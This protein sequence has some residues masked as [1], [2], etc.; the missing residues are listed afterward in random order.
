MFTNERGLQISTP[1]TAPLVPFCLAGWE[2]SS[3]SQVRNLCLGGWS[4]TLLFSTQL[5]VSS[6]ETYFIEVSGTDLLSG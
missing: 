4:T 6:N 5:P 3:K 2:W 1:R